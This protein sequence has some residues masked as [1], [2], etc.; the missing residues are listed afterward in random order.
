MRK[1]HRSLL[2][3]AMLTLTCLGLA[4]PGARADL[5]AVIGSN[6]NAAITTFLNASG[7]SATSFG[8][9]VPASLSGYDAV[10]L[11]RSSGNATL[12]NFV[13][14]GGLLIT[15]WS[16]SDWALDVANLLD[17]DDT[18]G[19]GVGWGTLV[20]FTPD[21]IAAGLSASLAN[22][23]SDA[24]R[25]EFFRHFAN[26]GPT[27]DVLGTRPGGA[28]A[29]IG[30]ASGSGSTLVIGY[31]WADGFPL[32][33]SASGTLLLNALEYRAAAAVPEP[34]SMAL[35]GVG[36]LLL[37]RRAKRSRVVAT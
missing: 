18:G 34:G 30:G 37:L 35:F 20:T 5:V 12:Q 11:L 22:P 2:L 25:T 13:L 3:R 16:A 27:V 32:L 26:I 31:D 21:G 23:Y 28:A 36:A 4:A 1:C 14:G 8:S 10:V 9:S 17:A 24:N 29:I 15:E 33:G 19:G 6:S 7:H